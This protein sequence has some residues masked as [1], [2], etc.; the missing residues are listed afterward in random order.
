MSL[1]KD[2]GFIAKEFETLDKKKSKRLNEG[3]TISAEALK[4][5]RHKKLREKLEDPTYKKLR[6]TRLRGRNESRLKKSK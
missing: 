5:R 3:K 4:K 2:V 6:Q 1:E